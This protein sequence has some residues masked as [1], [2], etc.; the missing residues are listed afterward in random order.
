MVNLLSSGSLSERNAKLFDGLLPTAGAFKQS[1][2][3]R[4]A[5][6]AARL[7]LGQKKILIENNDEA[8]SPGRDTVQAEAGF[9][10]PH[11]CLAARTTCE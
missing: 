4:Q 8:L 11:Q 1:D 9:R 3:Q 7:L 2:A 6:N 10:H 5:I